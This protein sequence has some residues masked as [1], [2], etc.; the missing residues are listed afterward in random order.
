MSIHGIG[1]IGYGGFGRFLHNSWQ[2]MDSVKIAAVA[3]EIVPRKPAPP[4]RFYNHWQDLVA[5]D[6]V[7]EIVVA[8]FDIGKPKHEVYTGC[9]QA[10]LNNLITRR[11]NPTHQLRVTIEDGLSSL[12]VA[13]LATQSADMHN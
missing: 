4:V 3:D 6:Q 7:E 11:E 9:V 10:I 13:Y 2:K 12:E 8:K 1:I 5:D